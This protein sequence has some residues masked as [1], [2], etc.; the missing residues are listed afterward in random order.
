MPAPIRAS[1][2]ASTSMITG[3]V[4]LMRMVSG[5]PMHVAMRRV[6]RPIKIHANPAPLRATRASPWKFTAAPV[7]LIVVIVISGCSGVC[8]QAV[9]CLRSWLNADMGR[10]WP[11]RPPMLRRSHEASGFSS[12]VLLHRSNTEAEERM[13]RHPMNRWCAGNI[14]TEIV[15][16]KN[17]AETYVRGQGNRRL[18][19]PLS[20]RERTSRL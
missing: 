6:E 20:P 10:L 3:T 19:R 16:R 15:A 18:R 17:F 5:S 14:N 1:P 12:N 7:E 11:S 8:V 9:L 2:N 4:G 13:S